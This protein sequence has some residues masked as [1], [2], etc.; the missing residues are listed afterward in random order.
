MLSE[1]RSLIA[2]FKRSTS[3]EKCHVYRVILA[4]LAQNFGVGV[5]EL[6]QAFLS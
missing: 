1:S 6:K 3:S 2:L 4:I 5:C